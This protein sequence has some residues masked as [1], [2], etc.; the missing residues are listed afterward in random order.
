[1]QGIG[2]FD[3][4]YIDWTIENNLI[5]VNH[6]HGISMYGADNCKIINN[7]VVDIDSVNSPNGTWIKITD[8]KNGTR[9]SNCLIQNNISFGFSY[10]SETTFLNNLLISD[11]QN[12]TNAMQ[13]VFSLRPGSIAIDGGKNSG[14]PLGDILGTPRP[15]NN[16]MDQGA[17]ES[18][19]NCTQDTWTLTQDLTQSGQEAV[20]QWFQTIGMIKVWSGTNQQINVGSFAQLNA[21]FEIETAATF[22]IH[23]GYCQ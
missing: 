7:T 12:F 14:A 10:G 8:H 21:G 20:N 1:M 17:F 6:Y 2:C 15:Q 9:S 13:G 4:P 22:E 18:I 11:Y 23:H 3:G 16:R 19:Y 5:V